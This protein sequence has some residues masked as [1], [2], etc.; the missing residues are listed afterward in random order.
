MNNNNNRRMNEWD[1]QTAR[2][3]EIMR[4]WRNNVSATIQGVQEEATCAANA[5]FELA[6]Q[7]YRDIIGG[8]RSVSAIA[9]DQLKELMRFCF[10]YSHR[11]DDTTWPVCRNSIFARTLAPH[12]PIQQQPNWIVRR[13]L[14]L[15]YDLHFHLQLDLNIRSRLRKVLVDGILFA[16]ALCH[17]EE[18]R[19]TDLVVGSP[20]TLDWWQYAGDQLLTL[21]TDDLGDYTTDRI[22]LDAV[23]VAWHDQWHRV[24]WRII[25]TERREAEEIQGI[26]D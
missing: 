4:H 19:A 18:I 12:L 13:G 2:N 16:A 21:L 11:V 23:G 1:R 20:S 10:S 25:W 14:W 15:I 8:T 24:E 6:E 17:E 22:I 3:A 7:L 26:L 9:F 5:G